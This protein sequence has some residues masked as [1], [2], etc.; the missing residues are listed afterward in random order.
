MSSARRTELVRSPRGFTLIELMVA[1]TA[2]LFVAIAAFALARQ[3][4]RFF[5]QEARIANAQFSATLGFDRLRAD[6]AR[7][8][9]LSSPNIQR[10]PFRCGSTAALPSMAA[11]RIVAATPAA[12]QDTTNELAPDQIT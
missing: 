8:G 1:I 7:A 4:S 9:F 2:G 10:D 3:G 12:V 11:V 5:Q 6:I